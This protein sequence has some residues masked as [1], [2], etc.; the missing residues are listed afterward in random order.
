MDRRT[1]PCLSLGILES[2]GKLPFPK[3]TPWPNL[4]SSKW[5]ELLTAWRMTGFRWARLFSFS[6]SLLKFQNSSGQ[7]DSLVLNS[8]GDLEF[9]AHRKTQYKYKGTNSV[10]SAPKLPSLE[11]NYCLKP[12]QLPALRVLL[13]PLLIKEQRTVLQLR[14]LPMPK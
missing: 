5:S 1:A 7:C 13:K 10:S 14:Q 6:L 2:L 4:A 8:T 3:R 11:W 9:S 12:S